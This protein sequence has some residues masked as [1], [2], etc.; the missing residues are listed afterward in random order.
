MG[1]MLAPHRIILC[2]L[3]TLRKRSRD[4]LVHQHR[5]VNSNQDNRPMVSPLHNRRMVLV[6]CNRDSKARNNLVCLN[7][8]NRNSVVLRRRVVQRVLP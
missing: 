2:H 7:M 8:L 5:V 3:R 4:I 1:Y 6:H